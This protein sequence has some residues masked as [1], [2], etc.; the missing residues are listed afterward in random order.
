[1]S[2][3]K[4]PRPWFVMLKDG[5]VFKV[6]ADFVMYDQD[7]NVLYFKKRLVN[8]PNP[9]YDGSDNYVVALFPFSDVKLCGIDG[10]LFTSDLVRR[11]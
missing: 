11:K 3:R 8:Q 4:T 9:S 2:K 6:I 7:E 1:M 10:Y 5:Y